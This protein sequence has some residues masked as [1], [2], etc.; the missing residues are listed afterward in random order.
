MF[1]FCK[2]FGCHCDIS[3][4]HQI[5]WS[6]GILD[7]EFQFHEL[8]I[9]SSRVPS[10]QGQDDLMT[11]LCGIYDAK[12]TRGGHYTCG[13]YIFTT[14]CRNDHY[15]IMD[16]HC[17]RKELGGNRNGLLNVFFSSE[18]ELESER[19]WLR[20]W[21]L[22]WLQLVT[23]KVSPAILSRSKDSK[24][25]F[26]CLYIPRSFHDSKFR[27]QALFFFASMC[28]RSEQNI[29]SKHKW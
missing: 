12:E 26:L 28:S 10:L 9:S 15:W 18:G 24:V 23:S 25:G 19:C 17:L 7:E 14:G 16:T 5:L 4:A 20:N 13:G 1:N 22:K 21:V 3:E 27:K 8:V 2:E 11:V 29:F 6:L